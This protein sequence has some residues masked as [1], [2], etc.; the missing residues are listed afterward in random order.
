[1][2]RALRLP[3]AAE[4]ASEL[5]ADLRRRLQQFD[6]PIEPGALAY[7]QRCCGPEASALQ[8]LAAKAFF[9]SLVR[10]HSLPFRGEV[11]QRGDYAALAQR[12]GAALAGASLPREGAPT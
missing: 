5:Q 10:R 6:H 3:L 12:I 2:G 8:Q 11:W 9:R 4:L 1:V 7:A